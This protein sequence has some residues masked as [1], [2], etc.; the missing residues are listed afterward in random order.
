MDAHHISPAQSISDH[1]HNAALPSVHPD[2]AMPTKAAFEPLDRSLKLPSYPPPTYAQSSEIPVLGG[3]PDSHDTELPPIKSWA[4]NNDS[5]NAS[6]SASGSQA[7]SLPSLASLTSGTPPGMVPPHPARKAPSPPSAAL[8]T[9]RPPIP[10]PPIPQV[11]KPAPAPITHWPSLNPLTAYYTPSHVEDG[12]SPMRMDLDTGSNSGTS[13]DRFADGRASSVSLDDPE[14]R[15]AAEALG[16]LKADLIYSPP[17]RST[18]LPPTPRSESQGPQSEPLLSLLTTS[19]PLLAKTIEGATS[20]YV[21][22]KNYSPRFKYGAEAVEG[23]VVPI[24]NTVGTVSRRTGM[25]SGVRWFLG[26]GRGLK[27]RNARNGDLDMGANKRRRMERSALGMVELSGVENL[28]NVHRSSRTSSHDRRLSIASTVDT[29]PAYDDARSPPYA[30]NG[31]AQNPRH[32]SSSASRIVISTSNLSIAM[33]EESLRSLKYCLSWL[34][35]ANVHIGNVI[36]S[37]KITMAKYEGAQKDDAEH[38]V[39]MDSSTQS[40]ERSQLEAKIVDYKADVLKT[41][42]D[43]INTVSKYAG[44]ALP[45]NA[46]ELVRQHLTSL[47]QRFRLATVIEDGPQGSESAPGTSDGQSLEAQDLQTRESAQRVMVLAKEGL[48]MMAQVSGVLDGTIVS[49]EEWCERMGQRKR[50]QREELAAAERAS[51]QLAP[52]QDVKAS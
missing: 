26:G 42:Q 44:G 25:E 22:S 32:S 27:S 41:L 34:R 12:G 37:L 31:T 33:S 5:S 15:M 28:T 19:H 52:L 14:V 10:I 2:G 23:V 48:D 24:A 49:A 45:D 16:E 43:V 38:P 4:P 35:W 6:A 30:E 20:T 36:D 18:P 40:T 17:S 3:R 7:T 11:A 50:E 47:P 13:P 21:N 39:L 9:T 51:V 1:S 46:R 8:P 29:L